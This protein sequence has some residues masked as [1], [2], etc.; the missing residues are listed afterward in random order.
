MSKNLKKAEKQFKLGKYSNVIR[1]LE[2]EVFKYRE[3]EKFYYYLGM[4]CLFLGDYSGAN[5]Y[6]RRALQINPNSDQMLGL[7]VIHLKHGNPSEAIRIWLDILDKEPDNKHAQRSL[8][9]LKRS[10]A[11][12]KIPEDFLA[13]NLNKFL[14][15]YKKTKV[16]NFI[17]YAAI[18]LSAL[19]I[20]TGLFFTSN[21]LLKN[22]KKSRNLYPELTIS[23]NLN[24]IV[25]EGE[26]KI[27]LQA[28]EIVALFES[29]KNYF[30]DNKDNEARIDINK[31]LNSNAS[32]AVKEKARLLDSY[33]KEPDYR[34]FKNSITYRMAAEKP[35]L[36]NNCYVKW[37]GKIANIR[38]FE[39]S[40]NFDFLIGYDSGKIVEGIV[41]VT[42][43]FPIVLDEQFT[44]D[45]IGQIKLENGHLA[46]KAISIR[47]YIK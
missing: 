11:L 34:Y 13:K 45:I 16:Y 20:L 21:Y 38:I 28:R 27:E 43:D 5:S 19:I 25:A 41:N 46:L 10:E 33:L 32:E 18:I 8:D 9:I 42:A 36:Y 17:H 15:F 4:S 7:A 2:P 39:K 12:E 1:L 37:S 29:A 14:P 24:D 44:Y 35:Y 30:I 47:N 22:L 23:R 6:L 40:V 31:L 3:N 26:F